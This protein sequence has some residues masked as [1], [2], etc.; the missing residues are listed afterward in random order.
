MRKKVSE[1][2]IICLINDDLRHLKIVRG[3]NMLGFS[4]NGM[5]SNIS[6]IVF[7]LMG[8]NTNDRRLDHLTDEYYDRSYQVNEIASNDSESF[9]RLAT[10]IFNW[11]STE[12]KKYRKQL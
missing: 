10:E 4:S 11:L 1:K 12:R 7:S 9:Q 2:T 6:Q 8:L 5:V 3:L